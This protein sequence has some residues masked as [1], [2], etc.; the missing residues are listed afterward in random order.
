M[1]DDVALILAIGIYTAVI[2]ISYKK[3]G[4]LPAVFW[5]LTIIIAG[6]MVYLRVLI[7]EEK[8]N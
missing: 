6:T 4:L 8:D 2:A 3:T 7:H 1:T 5:P